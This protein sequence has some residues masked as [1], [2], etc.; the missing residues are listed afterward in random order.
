MTNYPHELAGAEAPP[1][2]APDPDEVAHYL[3]LALHDQAHAPALRTAGPW[4]VAGCLL[5]LVDEANEANPNRSKSSDGTIGNAA[6]QA[7]KSDHNPDG[8]GVVRADDLTSLGLDLPAAFERGRQLTAA[9]RMPWLAGGGYFILNRRITAPDFSGWRVYTGAN[10]HIAHGHTSCSANPAVY[11]RRDR[12]GIFAPSST[13]T[14]GRFLPMLSDES[15]AT[16]ANQISQIHTILA[17]G[18]WPDR[19]K[20]PFYERGQ[21]TN[22]LARIEKAGE[23][24]RV[25]LIGGMGKGPTGAQL[26]NF[27]YVLEK[28]PELVA[29]A[30]VQVLGEGAV[31]P[32]A[33]VDLDQLAARVAQLVTAQ[34]GGTLAADLAGRLAD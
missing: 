21:I 16:L 29:A 30:V 8:N 28:M 5:Q 12:W 17:D 18:F 7:T 6:H 26:N 32:A 27:H 13:P 20:P 3:R 31:A 2:A 11:D 34:L 23:A 15:Q 24:A 9:G 22:T 19:S 1:P 10:P 25:A 33:D 4:R 14:P